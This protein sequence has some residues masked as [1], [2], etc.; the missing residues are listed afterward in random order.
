MGE[1]TTYRTG[2]PAARDMDMALSERRN[3]RLAEM[4]ENRAAAQ[5]DAVRQQAELKANRAEELSRNAERIATQ[6]GLGRRVDVSV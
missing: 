2:A 5:A 4:N 6:G 1:I 3:A